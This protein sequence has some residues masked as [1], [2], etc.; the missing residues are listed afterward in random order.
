GDPLRSI[1]WRQAGE[2]DG[3]DVASVFDDHRALSTDV[4]AAR[5]V[6]L[7]SRVRGKTVNRNGNVVP[8]F[9]V[10][11]VRHGKGLTLNP[12]ARRGC[13]SLLDDVREFVRDQPPS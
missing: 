8:G 11:Y 2:I 1:V 3:Y 13:M 4:I 12:F 6:R 5:V 7:W 9:Q 10:R